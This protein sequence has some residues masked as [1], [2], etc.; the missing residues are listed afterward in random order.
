MTNR[1]WYENDDFW[2]TWGPMIFS[3]QRIANTPI[4]INS[5]LTL[6][7]P[8]AKARVLDLCCGVGRHSLELAHRG[9]IVTGVDRTQVYL[10]QAEQ[11]AEQEGLEIEFIREDMRN[12]RRSATFDLA[13]NLFT[14]FGYF[15]DQADD[16]KVARNM[17][18]SL[19]P[20][21]V[22]LM[23]MSGKEI[24]ARDFREHDW[25]E[26]DGIYWLEER[27]VIDN[28]KLMQNRWIMFKDGQRYENT[29][30]NR[31]YSATELRA[32]LKEAGFQK[33]NIY[34]GLDGRPYDGMAKR[35]VVT[36]LKE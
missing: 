20:G 11:Q 18:D 17:Y 32:V 30:C 14:S 6:V 12:F 19:K 33:M 7:K 29:V 13:I 16:K 21:G 10:E 5:I 27:K 36:A 28:W 15:E 26:I 3:K 35:L 1:N 31:M 2:Q 23:E 4:E 34:G 25:H 22:L 9:F 24:V 8:P